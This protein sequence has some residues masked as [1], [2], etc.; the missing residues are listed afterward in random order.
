MHLFGQKAR[1]DVKLS[2][3]F[4]FRGGYADLFFQ[5]AFRGNRRVLAVLEPARGYLEQ[6]FSGR[7]PVL[8]YERDRAVVKNRH[9]DRAAAVNDDLALVLDTVLAYTIE[10]DV[11]DLAFVNRF[12]R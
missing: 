4:Y 12:R 5:L 7:V 11:K 10:T 6:V 8:P 1:R 2:Q 9:D 3:L